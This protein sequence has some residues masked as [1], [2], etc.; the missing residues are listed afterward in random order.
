MDRHI[1]RISE[2]VPSAETSVPL[3]LGS[4]TLPH[5]HYAGVSTDLEVHATGTLW[6]LLHMGMINL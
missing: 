5:F 6:R 3:E 4:L 1:G 2:R